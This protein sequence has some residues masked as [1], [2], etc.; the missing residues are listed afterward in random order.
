MLPI[1]SLRTWDKSFYGRAVVVVRHIGRY[2]IC[3]SFSSGPTWRQGTEL[4][5]GSSGLVTQHCLLQPSP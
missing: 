4:N 1:R 5:Y 3:G 2:L